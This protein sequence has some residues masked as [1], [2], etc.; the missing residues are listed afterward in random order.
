MSKPR[1]DDGDVFD[2][3]VRQWAQERPDVD[4][5]DAGVFARVVH[6]ADIW[7]SIVEGILAGH[8]LTGG[9]FD[10]LTALR[11]SGPPYTLTPSALAETTMMSRAGMTGRLDRLEEEGLVART[12]NADDRRSIRVSLTDHG[13]KVVDAAVDDH[14]AIL[15]PLQ[16]SLTRAERDALDQTLRTLLQT[17]EEIRF[18]AES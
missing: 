5:S 1:A 11:R 3:L 16:S 6:L 8:G 10:V 7:A 2:A 13:R 15:G 4:L 12:L 14:A 18:E 17:A 9:E